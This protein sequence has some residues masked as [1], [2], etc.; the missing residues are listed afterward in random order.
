VKQ[1]ERLLTNEE[2]GRYG[3]VRSDLHGT[4]RPGDG[5][6]LGSP[7]SV[8]SSRIGRFRMI[9]G[10]RAA[11]GLSKIHAHAS[12]T[13]GARDASSWGSIAIP[14]LREIA[15][16]FLGL[17]SLGRRVVSRKRNAFAHHLSQEKCSSKRM[18]STRTS[19]ARERQSARGKARRSQ[20]P[21]F[22]R[23]D[24]ERKACPGFGWSTRARCEELGG[25][26]HFSCRVA[27]VVRRRRC[28]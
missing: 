1:A 17:G 14:L 26:V 20:P 22:R 3:V 24:V 28:P 7:E 8:R 11:M 21:S 10:W 13:T 5:R 2:A 27:E 19:L 18:L 16:R 23:R 4:V 6:H 15:W 12:M 9:L 25:C